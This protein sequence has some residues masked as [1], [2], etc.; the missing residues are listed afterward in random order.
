MPLRSIHVA[1]EGLLFWCRINLRSPIILRTG[2]SVDCTHQKRRVYLSLE[3]QHLPDCSTILFLLGVMPTPRICAGSCTVLTVSLSSQYFYPAFS[4]VL[5]SPFT[6]HLL[7][8]VTISVSYCLWLHSF[9]CVF[10]YFLFLYF[11]LNETRGENWNENHVF[12][13]CIIRRLLESLQTYKI[14]ILKIA[15]CVIPDLPRTYDH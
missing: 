5:I 13:L 10:Y 12:N 8:V 6:F 7:Q 9:A 14:K 2:G 11:Y 4:A 1:Q 15:Y 3:R